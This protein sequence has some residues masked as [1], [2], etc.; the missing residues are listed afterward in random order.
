MNNSG[1]HYPSLTF[2]QEELA[3]LLKVFNTKMIPGT[4][5]DP[6]AGLTDD[7]RTLIL[8]SAERN[9]QARGLLKVTGDHEIVLDRLVVGLLGPCIRPE[10]SLLFWRVSQEL[11]LRTRFFHETLSI[12]VEHFIDDPGLHTFAALPNHDALRERISAFLSI[13]NPGEMD[14][15]TASVEL[16][17]EDFEAM[18]TR[19]LERTENNGA[20]IAEQ[21]GSEENAAVNSFET[22]SE[23]TT[24]LISKTEPQIVAEGVVLLKAK[25]QL[26]QVEKKGEKVLLTRTSF[27]NIWSQISAFLAT[28][29]SV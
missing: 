24:I 18:V 8:S 5:E 12:L 29:N 10:S 4:G 17:Q 22:F 28:T 9:L 23:L 1:P 25:D 7:Q 3:L 14:I 20:A 21:V 26:W 11:G 13:Q 27:Q 2:S 6:L 19:Q 15:K 16:S